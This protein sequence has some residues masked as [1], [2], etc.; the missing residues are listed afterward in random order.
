MDP[1][2]FGAF[3]VPFLFRQ[4]HEL[5]FGVKIDP[6]SLLPGLG[7]VELRPVV[8]RALGH[9]EVLLQQ[10]D[11]VVDVPAGAEGGRPVKLHQ[12]FALD[13]L[14]PRSDH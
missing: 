10:G 2:V 11:Q 1:G 8:H 14:R 12:N 9:A 6:S 5:P 13:H 3:F 7:L 4:S